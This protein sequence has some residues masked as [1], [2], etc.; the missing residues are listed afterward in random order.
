[1]NK[2]AARAGKLARLEVSGGKR[3]R[4]LWFTQVVNG[5]WKEE[6]PLVASASDDDRK[7]YKEE[8]KNEER[9][10]VKRWRY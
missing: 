3:A 9:Q 10:T 1:M 6:N 7:K 4:I 8:M 5:D 2:F